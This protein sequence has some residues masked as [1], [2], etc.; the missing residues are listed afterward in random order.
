M[1]NSEPKEEFEIA[2]AALKHLLAGI[3]SLAEECAEE[4]IENRAR[5]V[6]EE[7]EKCTNMSEIT[8]AKINVIALARFMRETLT[9]RV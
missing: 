5:E 2:K 1:N 8:Q 9:G 3:M 7:A 4:D 6:F